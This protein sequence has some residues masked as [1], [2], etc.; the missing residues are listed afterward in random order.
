[1]FE[2]EV[3]SSMTAID[4]VEAAYIC[5]EKWTEDLIP[6]QPKNKSPFRRF[7]EKSLLLKIRG[8]RKPFERKPLGW[9]RVDPM[10]TGK[11]RDGTTIW[12]NDKVI[13]QTAGILAA[14]CCLIMLIGPL[15]VLEHVT[16]IDKRLGVITGFI[17][18]FFILVSLA[19]T[20]KMSDAVGA[21]AAYAAVLV[22]FLTLGAGSG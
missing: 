18:G 3:G 16:G 12:E 13:D 14:I 10:D 22:V 19:T 6:V 4:D 20:A 1:M 11:D 17:V 5:E 9:E 21:A 8:I 15:W 7:L 2:D